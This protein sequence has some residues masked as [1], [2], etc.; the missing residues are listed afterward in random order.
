[1]KESEGLRQTPTKGLKVFDQFPRELLDVPADQLWQHL[2]GPS[3]FQISGLNTQPLF[4]S[5][6]LHGNETTGWQAIQ[7]VLKKF[8][9]A[10]LPRTLLL[11][12]GN[13]PAARANVRTLPDQTDYNRVW[14]GTPFRSASETAVMRDVFEI[15]RHNKPFAAIDVHNNTGINPHYA[16]VTRLDEESLHLARMF[17]RTV[18]YFT[19]PLG[20]QTRAFADICPAVTVECGRIGGRASLDYAIDFL[21]Q[22]LALEAFPEDPVPES[23]IDL[24]QTFAILKVPANAT[25]SF[26]GS[27]A[28]F[29]FREDID[30]LNFSELEPG[31]SWGSLA[32]AS[33]LELQILCDESGRAEADLFEYA[34]GEIILRKRAIP[35]MLTRDVR[36]VELDCLGY[37]MHRIG[38]DGVQLDHPAGPAT[39]VQPEPADKKPLSEKERQAELERFS[40]PATAAERTRFEAIQ[41]MF[42]ESF[43]R[44]FED[45]MLPRT[46]IINPSLSL[47]QEVMAKVTGVNHYEERLL[48]LLL[49]LRMPRT[50]VVYLSS[51]PIP[52]AIV[53]YYLKMLAGIPADEARTRLTLLSCDDPSPVPLTFKLLSRPDLL[54]RIQKTIIDP[55]SAHMGCFTVS[56]L[57]R[58]LALALGV[59]IYGCDPS[60]EYWGSKSGSRRIFKEAGINVPPGFEDLSNA[61]EVANALAELKRQHPKLTKAVVKINEG[62]SGEGNATVDLTK[63]PAGRA[64]KKWFR[65]N[66]PNMRYEAS[67]MTWELYQSK[68]EAMGGIV[69]AFIPGD[70]KS[71]PSAQFRVNPLGSLEAISTHDQILSGPSGQIFTGCRFPA[72]PDYR[73]EIQDQ[74]MRAAQI[75]ADKGALG[76]IGVDFVSVRQADGW[77]HAA[78]EINLRRG[79]TTHPFLMLQFLTDGQYD[80]DSGLFRTQNGNS[81]CYYASDNIESADYRG[82]QPQKLIDRAHAEGLCFDRATEEG[83]AF[84]LMGALS[85][86]GKL[87]VVCIASS[88]DRADNLF[89][90]TV[91][92]VEQASKKA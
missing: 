80:P 19:R 38:S 52:D 25:L 71:S 83:V 51:M 49:L 10:P 41:D 9:S 91:K 54:Q 43:L 15:V 47:D 69:E 27:E 13:I 81:R 11:F 87:G 78:I 74:G 79:G 64:D 14:P 23:E 33:K 72:D 65:D 37:L 89:Q 57:E 18:V 77:Q 3:L 66:L 86:F 76:R 59:P 90:R 36:A 48:C 32:D 34:G 56:E 58:R 7:A 26:D 45:S 46:V 61:E 29:Q 4:V 35:A 68:L 39:N 42:A 12:V 16:C 53:D 5:A 8:Q 1:M 73:L 28:D 20:V 75:L 60:L 22:A 62:F 24:L 85:E 2:T 6:L 70:I 30:S 84:H 44:V 21:A 17:S 82:L 92:L 55:R 88:P 31:T 50:H 67:G 40:A 63:A